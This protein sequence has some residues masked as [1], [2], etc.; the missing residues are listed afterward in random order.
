MK[1]KVALGADHSGF[2]LKNTLAA[3]LQQSYQTVDYGTETFNRDDDYHDFTLAVA[4]SVVSGQADRGIIIRGRGVGATIA[5]NKMA[6]ARACLCHDTYSANQKVEHDG[7]K[8]LCLRSRIIGSE[9]ALELVLAFLSAEFSSE[10]RH[11]RCLEKTQ[12]YT[13]RQSLQG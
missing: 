2:I 10:E 12:V 7:T 11:R 3:Q 9:M 6:G 5:A 4:R 1:L 8:I 13:E